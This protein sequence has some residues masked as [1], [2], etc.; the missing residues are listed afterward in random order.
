MVLFLF[1]QIV[2]EFLTV[3]AVTRIFLVMVAD[4]P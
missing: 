4:A 3:G 1:F 2:P